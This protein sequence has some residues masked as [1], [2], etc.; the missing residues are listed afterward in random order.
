VLPHLRTAL[1][2]HGGHTCAGWLLC[3]VAAM[4]RLGADAQATLGADG[5]VALVQPLTCARDANV[6]R[7]AN[8]A[9]AALTAGCAANTAR[10]SAAGGGAAA[11]ALAPLFAHLAVAERNAAGGGDVALA[12]RTAAALR[13]ALAALPASV[14]E[15]S[16]GRDAA[17][18]AEIAW[19]SATLALGGDAAAACA[20]CE[21]ALPH[22]GAPNSGGELTRLQALLPYGNALLF[23]GRA[24]DAE[25]ALLEA[26][27]LARAAPG[28]RDAW[29]VCGALGNARLLRGAIDAAVDALADGIACAPNAA[30]RR[31]LRLTLAN[32]CELRGARFADAAQHRVALK[33]PMPDVCGV[34]LDAIAP[35]RPTA[36]DGDWSAP[37]A[38]LLEVLECCHMFHQACMSAWEA[39]Q[40]AQAGG[41]GG[42]GP[43][44]TCPSCR[45]SGAHAAPRNPAAQAATRVPAPSPPS[46]PPPRPRALVYSMPSREG[47]VCPGRTSDGGRSAPLPSDGACLW[48]GE[49][50]AAP[51]DAAGPPAATLCLLR[52]PGGAGSGS[53]SCIALDAPLP[54][55]AAARAPAVGWMPAGA[56]L[57][58]FSG[59]LPVA[60]SQ[61]DDGGGI[62]CSASLLALRVRISGADAGATPS[63]VP[64]STPLP[65]GRFG[66]A[67]A[68]H[69][70]AF[71]VFGGAKRASAAAAA[72][73]WPLEALWDLHRFTPADASR[74][75]AGGAWAAVPLR[76]AAPPARG[77]GGTGAVG[78]AAGPGL[79]S[80]A[81]AQRG[82]ELYLFLGR[83]NAG[84]STD[85]FVVDLPTGDV[86]CLAPP[87]G[88]PAPPPRAA[89]T[90]AP[91][92]CGAFLV[93]GGGTGD[94]DADDAFTFDPVTHAWA[95]VRAPEGL[96]LGQHAVLVAGAAG[97]AGAGAAAAA[98]APL[99]LWGGALYAPARAAAGGGGAGAA[100]EF[101]ADVHSLLLQEEAP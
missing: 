64:S 2:R 13:V 5:F 69:G 41:G 31:T 4:A 47:L 39:A 21:R 84:Y 61:R 42:G 17:A 74:P 32:A 93:L 1:A 52:P 68:V 16:R 59:M 35:T 48:F 37:R 7:V 87:L 24:A 73:D 29:A 98:A 45:R 38:S 36:P 25:A 97:T 94:A 54:R 3:V 82:R 81:A 11:A 30:A 71:Y 55:D 72:A 66:A 23:A 58:S 77:R 101:S 83:T 12:A 67:A 22:A 46:T 40:R 43:P 92:P 96:R 63:I 95:R 51:W 65:C 10:A 53:V 34:C 80:A 85:V 56:T 99:L 88:L 49:A 60:S 89:A 50:A 78:T 57:L 20:A 26:L 76:G 100:T 27:P 75:W 70:G 79:H 9:L 19:A 33:V 91:L 18:R 86:R 62:R 14:R 6:A 28:A 90:A 8:E 44:A 15:S